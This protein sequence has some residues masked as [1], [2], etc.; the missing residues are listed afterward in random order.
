VKGIREAARRHPYWVDA[1]LAALLTL[2][3]LPATVERGTGVLGWV[4]FG[5]LPT[6]LV[7]RRRAPVV[8][9]W[10][11]FV[12]G[13]S[14]ELAGA[15]LPASLVAVMAAVYAVACHRPRR[16]LWPAVAALEATFVLSAA[17]DSA[18]ASLIPLSAS[19]AAVA[20]LGMTI[21]T[22]RAYLAELVERA[23][24]LEHERDQQ[25]QLATAA[26]R[27]RIAREMHD[28][29]AHNL[30]VMVSLA[31][32]AALTATTAPQ[33]AA[34][35]M[36]QVAAT[37]REALS[38]MRRLLGLLEPAG[39]GLDP[40]PG[41]DDIDRLVDQV[42]AAGLRVVLTRQGAPGQWGPGA[43]LTVYRIVQE[44]LTNTIKHAGP[45]ATAQIRLS[46]TPSLVDIE[47][48]DDGAHRPSTSS[49]VGRG[50]AGMRERVAPYGGRVEAGPLPGAGWR[51]SARLRLD[52]RV[53]A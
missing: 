24:R 34:E 35:K 39:T 36:H 53:A 27:A 22:R 25:A 19:L 38:E 23:R 37:G 18:W 12:I 31:D 46:Y 15:D 40:Q 32:A 5:V 48:T 21:S 47:V 29:V 14:A 26:E 2:V 30:A 17:S 45:A 3:A 43:G 41:L 44:A 50:L 4:L 6:L 51:V 1:G 11:V 7:W 52:Q 42:R 8:V 9:F 13:W 20:L 49:M 28:I 10:T 33:G 16:Y